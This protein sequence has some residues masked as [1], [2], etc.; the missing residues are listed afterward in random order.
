MNKGSGFGNRVIG[1]TTNGH[2]ALKI[3]MNTLEVDNDLGDYITPEHVHYLVRDQLGLN[4]TEQ[5]IK[6][7]LGVSN[8]I[9]I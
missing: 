8:P 9:V 3:N 5:G 2:Y 6:Y 7:A 1:S 4:Q